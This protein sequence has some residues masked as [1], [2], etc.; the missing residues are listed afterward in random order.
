[1]CTCNP[2]YQP[3]NATHCEG[4]IFHKV[5]HELSLVCPQ[6]SYKSS[7]GDEACKRMPTIN[8]NTTKLSILTSCPC[9][10]GYSRREIDDYI[11]TGKFLSAIQI[12]YFLIS[13]K[14]ALVVVTMSVLQVALIKVTPFHPSQQSKCIIP[15]PWHL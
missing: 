1:M 10:T 2:G 13:L 11:C 4:T 8:S 15:L 3:I 7:Q 6:G 5:C 14:L 9:L 12:V